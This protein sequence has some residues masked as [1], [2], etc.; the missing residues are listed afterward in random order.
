MPTPTLRTDVENATPLPTRMAEVLEIVHARTARLARRRGDELLATTSADEPLLRRYADQA[1]AEIAQRLRIGERVVE[2]AVTPGTTDYALPSALGTIDRVTITQPTG[3]GSE[4][5]YDVP[6]TD[7]ATL[8]AAAV[9]GQAT[10]I[11]Y[12]IHENRLWLAQIAAAGTVRL[13]VH[14]GTLL[15]DDGDLVRIPDLPVQD[16]LVLLVLERWF[17]DDDQKADAAI[18]RQTAEEILD[19]GVPKNRPRTGVRRGTYL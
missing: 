7:G 19:R 12:G 16:L 6:P 13:Y 2:V 10:E 14:G 18:A 8:R 9:A 5:T 11:G 17:L 15:G 3:T 1:Q 4:T